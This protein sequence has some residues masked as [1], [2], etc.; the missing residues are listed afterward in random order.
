MLHRDWDRYDTRHVVFQPRGM[1]TR[2]LEA[3]Y[4]RAYRD[5]Y[6]WGAI[7]R[8]ASTKDTAARPRPPRSPTPAGGRSSSRLWNLAIRG[9]QVLRA[10]P[11]L[12]QVLAGFGERPPDTA[13]DTAPAGRFAGSRR[14]A[15]DGATRGA[16]TRPEAAATPR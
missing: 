8:G 12:E 10:L 9:R 4:W 16:S 1:T 14:P 6:R 5:F 3:G 11:L 7:A 13:P 15:G 2:Q